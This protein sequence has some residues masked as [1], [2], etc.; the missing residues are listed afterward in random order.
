MRCQC[1]FADPNP[2]K[3]LLEAP[4][5]TWY[6]VRMKARKRIVVWIGI[7]VAT[8]AVATIGCAPRK[9]WDGIDYASYTSKQFVTTEFFATTTRVVMQDDYRQDGADARAEETWRQAVAIMD[10]LYRAL[11]PASEQSD[12]ARWNAAQ[13]SGADLR[14]EISRVTYEAMLAAKKLYD[15]TDGLYNPAGAR[16]ADLWGFSPRFY[17]GQT[18]RVYPY[19]RQDSRAQL[20]DQKYIAGFQTL[21]QTFK[22]IVLSAD[23]EKYYMTKPGDS[24]VEIDGGEIYWAWLDLGGIA[25]G[26][27]ANLVAQCLRDNGY[28]FG[29]V[30]VGGSSAAMLCSIDYNALAPDRVDWSVGIRHPRKHETNYLNVYCHDATVSTSG[31]Y[32]RYYEIDGERYCHIIDPRTGRPTDSGMQTVSVIGPDA[33]YAD[34]LTTALCIADGDQIKA[35]LAKYPEYR[36]TCIGKDGWTTDLPNNRYKLTDQT[37]RYVSN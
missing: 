9:Q 19:D 2:S 3:V 27:A 21:T 35:I 20:P 16:C 11:D 7:V 28:R 33:A 1:A 12:I 25:K 5:R 24:S 10:E 13:P 23:D 37:V 26:I 6:T 36:Y 34:A 17:R 32:E 29:Y 22:K 30:S 14:I 18:D 15:D 8:V 31:D 4:R